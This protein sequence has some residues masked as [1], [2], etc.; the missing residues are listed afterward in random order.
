VE[1]EIP[2]DPLDGPSE[3]PP[4]GSFL[5]SGGPRCKDTIKTI[6]GINGQ[7]VSIKGGPGILVTASELLDNTIV[8]EADLHGMALCGTYISSSIG[9]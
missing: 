4:E 1:D 3:T 8:V 7:T 9:G 2:L 6:N 5:L